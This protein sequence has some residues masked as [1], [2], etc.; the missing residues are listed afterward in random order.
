[1]EIIY[2]PRRNGKTMDIITS[3]FENQP[4]VIVVSNEGSKRLVR[5]R[6]ERAYKDS[7]IE[8]VL[9]KDLPSYL[10]GRR[11]RNIYIDDLNL[12][13]DEYASKK[14]EMAS[15]DYGTPCQESENL[16]IKEFGDERCLGILVDG[17]PT[18]RMKCQYCPYRYKHPVTRRMVIGL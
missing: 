17:S 8:V 13:L 14:I 10:I 18:L 5:K 1:M 4:S 7:D 3:A 12:C 15:I 2:K 11:D 6:I 9:F 16:I